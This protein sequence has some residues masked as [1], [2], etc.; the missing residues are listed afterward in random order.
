MEATRL[1][2][3]C[4]TGHSTIMF[5]APYNADFE[6]EKWEELIPVA[7][8]RKQNYLDIGESIDPQD[9]V[10]GTSSDTIYQR[11]IDG[12]NAMTRSKLS[13]NI[14]LLHD[15]GGEDRTATV[16]ALPRIIEYFQAR[17]FHF[18][19]VADILGKS[20]D[21]LMPSVP[22]GSGYY[23][24]Q[25]NYYFAELG[26]WGGHILFS[27]FI[28]FMILSVGRVTV[29]LLYRYPGIFPGKE[30]ALTALLVAGR[31]ECSRWSAL[32]YRLIMKK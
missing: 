30:K 27:M 2:I 31:Y 32:S 16:E 1:L 26:Y 9:W 28:T 3:E 23:L 5:R 15:A 24:L 20:K 11:T 7:I 12:K 29:L 22:K 17:G 18:T 10:P 19:T 6:P 4:I 25:I 8:A 14:I 13:G 21:E